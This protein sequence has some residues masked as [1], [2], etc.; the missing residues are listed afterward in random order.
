LGRRTFRE[1]V[2]TFLARLTIYP[3]LAF[4]CLF[5]ERATIATEQARRPARLYQ[6][7]LELEQPT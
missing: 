2:V 5:D 1:S 3:L 6:N 4:P 7:G